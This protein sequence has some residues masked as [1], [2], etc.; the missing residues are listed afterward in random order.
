MEDEIYRLSDRLTS[1]IDYAID[2]GLTKGQIIERLR[3]AI[4]D[5][6]A[7]PEIPA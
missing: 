7:D 5:V 1:A 2:A 6:E 3:S 4:E